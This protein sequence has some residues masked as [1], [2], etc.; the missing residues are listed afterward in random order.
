MGRVVDK[1]VDE[2]REQLSERKVE[3]ELT[4]AARAWLAEKGYDPDFG[5]RALARV[6]QVELKDRVVDDLLFGQLAKGGRVRVDR[7]EDGLAF[8]VQPAT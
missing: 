3:I 5:A 8:S 7:G 4:E 6:I 1:F 2:V